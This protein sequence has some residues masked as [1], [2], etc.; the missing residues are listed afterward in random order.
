MRKKNMILCNIFN[1]IDCNN[2]YI[3]NKCNNSNRW[4]TT[5]E[6][7]PDKIVTIEVD[8]VFDL[9]KFIRFDGI[10]TCAN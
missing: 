2:C 1:S 7:C 9:S 5:N 6:P 3:F 10:A 8:D 4:L